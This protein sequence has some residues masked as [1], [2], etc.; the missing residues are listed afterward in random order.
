MCASRKK[1]ARCVL[2]LG[3]L[4]GEGASQRACVLDWLKGYLKNREL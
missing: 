2:L 1:P 4:R 3:L